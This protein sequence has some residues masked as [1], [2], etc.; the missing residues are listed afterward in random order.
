V[1]DSLIDGEIDFTPA[2]LGGGGAPCLD[3]KPKVKWTAQKT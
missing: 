3:P 2:V 1:S